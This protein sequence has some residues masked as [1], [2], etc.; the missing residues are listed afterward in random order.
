MTV[1]QNRAITRVKLSQLASR[2]LKAGRLSTDTYLELAKDK[3]A[4]GQAIAVLFLA[5]LGYSIGYTLLIGPLALDSIL[6]GILTY[7]IISLMAGLLWAITT[8]LV[9]TKLFKGKTG[10]WGLARP[11]FFASS[12]GILFVLIA[13]PQDLISRGVAA[14]VAI[15]IVACGVVALKTAMG[16]SYQRSMLTYIVGF[17]VGIA[18]SYFFGR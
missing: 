1:V 4:N 17:L 16:F 5:T 18:I 12:P 9:G 13:I 8:F 14:A 10:C 7:L 15:W 11:L 2:M 3:S 6:V